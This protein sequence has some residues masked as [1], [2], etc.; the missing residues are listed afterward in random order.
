MVEEMVIALIHGIE[1]L[2]TGTG[3]LQRV[4]HRDVK[5]SNTLLDENWATKVSDFRLCKL[6]PANQSCTHVSTCVKGTPGYCD[7][8]YFLTHW[9]TRKSDVFSFGV[10][11][12]EVLS[13][14]RALDLRLPKNKG[15]RACK[16]ESKK[17][18][19]MVEVVLSLESALAIQ[20]SEDSSLLN[21]DIFDFGKTYD[22]D[23]CSLQKACTL[24]CPLAQASAV[25]CKV[26]SNLA[27]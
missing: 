16:N 14:K 26:G 25:N 11:L 20:T 24:I 12:F 22:I 17:R 10:V 15:L 3:V 2:H 23:D 9:V 4:I 1:Y 13:G 21:K 6:G 7:P 5:S 27:S 19:T 8:D 18:P